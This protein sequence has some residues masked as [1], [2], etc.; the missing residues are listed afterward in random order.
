[1]SQ[2]GSLVTEDGEVLEVGNVGFRRGGRVRVV[3]DPGGPSMTKQEFADEC[4]INNI[5][6]NYARTGMISH[7]N[8]YQGSYEDVS[9]AVS[10]HEAQE[11]VK[12]AEEMF[13]TVPSAVRSKFDNDP[14]KF[15]D[16]VLDDRN[17]DEM[18]KMGLLKE[19]ARVNSEVRQEVSS[20]GPAVEKS[21]GSDDGKSPK[22]SA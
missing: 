16:F 21:G 14:G 10:F 12:K 22:V 20:T 11:I 6:R 13:Y 9:G 18:Q 8:K 5:M 4:D 19:V 2:Y 3:A 15:L 7:V 17:R 1:M